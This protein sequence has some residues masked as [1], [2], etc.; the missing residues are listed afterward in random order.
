MSFVRFVRFVVKS[1][2]RFAVPLPL[3]RVRT[4][5]HRDVDGVGEGLAGFGELDGEGVVAGEAGGGGVEAVLGGG[6]AVAA[7]GARIGR[8]EQ[9]MTVRPWALLAFL[10]RER[11]V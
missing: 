11:P 10:D 1:V 2:F 6:Q 4:L 5:P 7:V 3:R 8:L 9:R